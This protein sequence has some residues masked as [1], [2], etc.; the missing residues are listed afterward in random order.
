M[1]KE[2]RWLGMDMAVLWTREGVLA[3]GVYQDR[4]FKGAL[5]KPPVS[6]QFIKLFF[7][8]CFSDDRSVSSEEKGCPSPHLD[9]SKDSKSEFCTVRMELCLG[10]S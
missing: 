9:T 5:D 1:T 6:Y 8:S 10:T 2:G 3:P 7:S 4:E